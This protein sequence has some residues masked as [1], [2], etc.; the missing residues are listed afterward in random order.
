MRTAIHSHCILCGCT[1]NNIAVG[2]G[3]GLLCT[4]RTIAGKRTIPD[5]DIAAAD[6]QNRLHAVALCGRCGH[7]NV[8]CSG[9]EVQECH[10][11]HCQ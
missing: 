5:D 10:A 2:I 1:C 6:V 9:R 8:K 7:R 4:V 3:F 11:A